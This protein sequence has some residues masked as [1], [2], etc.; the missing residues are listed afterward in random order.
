VASALM[1]VVLVAGGVVYYWQSRTGVESE[2]VATTAA[3]ESIPSVAPPVTPPA[4]TPAAPPVEP[5][6]APPKVPSLS[7]AAV[8]PILAG[9]PCSALYPI[10][11]D[12]ALQVQGYLPKSFGSARLKNILSSVPGATSVELNLQEVGDDECSVIKLF[13]RYWVANRQAGAAASIRTKKSNTDLTEGDPL[14]VDIATPGYDSYVNLDYYQLDGRVVHLLPSQRARD[15]QAPAKY[16]ATIGS[17]GNWVIS[18]PFGTE[19]LA[20][21]ITPVPLFDGLRAES[22]PKAD[23]LRAVEKRLEQIGSKYGPEKIA[24]DFVQITTK[25]RKP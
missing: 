3:P 18:K 19:L 4:A 22:E 6:K 13:A 9:V 1:I 5:A 8:T 17:L 12:H 16:T 2:L 21:L 10:V 20:L 24:V 7:L 14:I 11:G 23:Y 25:A 15:N